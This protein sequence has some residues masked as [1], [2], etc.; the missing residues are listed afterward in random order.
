MNRFAC[1]NTYEA[2][3]N[4][5]VRKVFDRFSIFSPTGER[6]ILSMSDDGN[7]IALKLY[8]DMV[9]YKKIMRSAPYREAFSLY[10][11]AAGIVT[12]EN[13]AWK[14][15]GHAYP[16]SYWALGYYLITYHRDSYLKE[17]ETIA[18]IEAMPLKVRFETA[19]ELAI[20]CIEYVA[21]AEGVNLAGRILA[22]T[23]ADADLFAAMQPMISEIAANRS[24]EG[25]S[26]VTGPCETIEECSGMAETFFKAAAAEGYVYACNSLAMREAERIVAM[27]LADPEES[28]PD[29][30]AG[31]RAR[32]ESYLHYLRLAAD[33]Y[34]P[35]AANRLG[36]FYRTGEVRSAAGKAVFKEYA[37]PVLA[38]EYFYKATVYP[39]ANSAW[40]F[41]NL[42]KYYP[43]D[44]IQNIE[45]MDEHMEYMKRLNPEVYDIVMDL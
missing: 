24:I 41:F 2:D 22:E 4:D 23:A 6:E 29:Q 40:A 17:C 25:L 39:D 12:D 43:N 27:S 21:S 7:T 16:L 37:D 20:A 44:Y 19:F 34:E 8:A 30:G 5:Y 9:F 28:V 26:L 3:L 31:L 42:Q 1:D 32:I 35:Y 36:L 33:K 38:K 11:R 10:K 18:E 14:C 13:G 15:G 45:L